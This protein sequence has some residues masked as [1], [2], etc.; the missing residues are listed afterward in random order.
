[1]Y[2]HLRVV[3]L[4]ANQNLPKE[5]LMYKKF[6]LILLALALSACGT[7]AFAEAPDA[8]GV[9]KADQVKFVQQDIA[10]THITMLSPDGWLSEYY[11]GTTTIVSDSKNLFYSPYEPFEGARI[12]LFVSDGPRAVGPS[13][14][15]MKLARDYVADQP[16]VIQ[17]PTLVEDN[18]RQIVTT[19]YE[20]QDTKGPLITYLVGFVMEEQQL[21]VFIA[22][23]PND[24]EMIYLP[25]LQTMLNSIEIRS[26]L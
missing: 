10:H 5:K 20:K 18:G 8:A 22:A 16:N 13:F 15:V 25:I 26:S 24:T 23:T 19:L 2:L 7:S 4:N 12:D 21:T 3:I 6:V 14:D 11:Q 17:A 9:D 1:V